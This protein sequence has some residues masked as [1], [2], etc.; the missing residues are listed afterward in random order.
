MTGNNQINE[1]GQQGIGGDRKPVDMWYVCLPAN[2]DRE[3]YIANCMA[4]YTVSLLNMN[5]ERLHKIPVGKCAMQFIEFPADEN[6]LGSPCVCVNIEGHNQLLVVEVFNFGDQFNLFEESE[7]RLTEKTA[8]GYAEVSIKGKKGQ[9]FINVDSELDEGGEVSINIANKTGTGKFNINVNGTLKVNNTGKT[10][11]LSSDEIMF[12][13][14]DGGEDGKK[15]YLKYTNGTGLT[16][17]DEFG[18]KLTITQD[19]YKLIAKKISLGEGKEPLVLGDTL[20]KLLKDFIAEVGKITTTTS[21]GVQPI[22]NKAQ[23]EALS[24][25][26]DPILSKL[27]F[28]D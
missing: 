8:N 21:I 27:S 7:K 15:T 23:I 14:D 24:E 25:K 1:L 26:V 3:R 11:I 13:V 19:L 9:V 12:V 2:E 10:E 20:A 17:E 22:M 18:N 6:S 5:N 28:T 16:Y 4:T